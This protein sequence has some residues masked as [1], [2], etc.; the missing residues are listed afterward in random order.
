MIR[1]FVPQDLEQILNI[2]LETNLQAHPFV[3]ASYW[4]GQLEGVGQALPQAE[5]YVWEEE[6]RVL[7]FLGLVEDYIAGIFVRPGCQSA[8]VGKQL[9][10]RAKEVREQL[11]LHV[12]RKNTRAAAFYR[13]EGFSPLSEQTDPATGEEELE[14]VWREGP[15][16]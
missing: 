4:R 8:G 13:R 2:W 12:Y 10:D 7:G 9:L 1:P 3:P 15:L 11:T 14:M 5:V 6:G 16:C